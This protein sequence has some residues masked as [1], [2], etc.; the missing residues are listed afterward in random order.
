MAIVTFIPINAKLKVTTT[1][2][3][4]IRCFR[5]SSSSRKS[6]LVPG[7]LGLKFPII[8]IVV[9]AAIKFNWLDFNHLFV[10]IITVTNVI[11]NFI[12]T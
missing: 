9:N 4:I 1:T 10:V 5:C 2:I 7:I 8:I 12:Y 6:G 3:V 11:V